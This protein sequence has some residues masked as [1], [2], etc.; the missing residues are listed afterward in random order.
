MN[1]NIV[2][3]ILLFFVSLCASAQNWDH[4]QHSGEYYYGVGRGATR[5]EATKRAM[6]EL[7]EMIATHVSNE[8][9]D[10]DEITDANGN[11][12]HKS[13]VLNCIKTYSQSTLTNVQK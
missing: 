12:D 1:R 9:V 3:S 10:I 13:R 6:A 4:I 8:F 2:F 7:I 11:T 5:E